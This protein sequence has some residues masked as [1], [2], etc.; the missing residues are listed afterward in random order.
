MQQDGVN[1]YMLDVLP[2]GMASHHSDYCPTL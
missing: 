2:S 1:N